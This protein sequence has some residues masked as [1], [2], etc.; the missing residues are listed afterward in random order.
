MTMRMRQAKE[1]QDMKPSPPR[2]E[3]KMI[4]ATSDKTKLPKMK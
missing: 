4:K 1:T 3:K 2:P